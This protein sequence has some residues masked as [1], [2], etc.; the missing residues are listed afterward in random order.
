MK[1]VLTRNISILVFLSFFLLCLIYFPDEVTDSIRNSMRLCFKTVIPSLFPFFVVSKLIINLNLTAFHSEHL[2]RTARKLFSFGSALLPALVLGFI[3]GYPIGAASV[4]DTYKNGYCSKEEAERALSFC[5]NTGPAF[6]IGAT[7][8]GFLGSAKLGTMLYLI[9]IIS[10]LLIG[11]FL[12]IFSPIKHIGAVKQKRASGSVSFSFAFTDSIASSINSCINISAY[13]IFF[14]VLI[15]TLKQTMLLPLLCRISAS[16]FAADY[17]LIFAV[18]SGFL[19]MTVGIASIPKNAGKAF[20]LSIISFLI[21]WGGLSVHSQT[22]SVIENAG[23]DTKRYFISKFI[24]GILSATF[25]YIC[26]TAESNGLMN[27]NPVF[28]LIALTFI[29]L[30]IIFFVK[31]TGKKSDNSV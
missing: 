23:L 13:I 20:V 16:I 24:H 9:H 12:G 19:E 4:Y 18:F 29:S 3:G 5:N 28:F 2:D 15:C 25:T 6:I 26:F 7:G 10:A 14:S 22:L 17:E 30:S 21:S 1:R 31:N 11:L 27:L 8:I